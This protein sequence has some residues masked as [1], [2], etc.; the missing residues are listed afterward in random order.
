MKLVDWVKDI[1]QC[2]LKSESVDGINRNDW[3]EWLGIRIN[4]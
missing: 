1:L 2:V 3:T 4:L